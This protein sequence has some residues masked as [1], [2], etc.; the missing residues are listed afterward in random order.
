MTDHVADLDTLAINTI[1]TLAMDA[2][3]AAN[4]GHPGT[5]MSMAPVAY[6]LW[7]RLLRFDPQR[8]DWPN[9]DRFVLSVGH[10]S[11]LL[12]SLL[13]LS[14]VRASKPRAG[15]AVSLDD[16]KRFRQL[17]SPCAGHPEYDSDPAHW[18]A[19]VEA[20][21]G[22]LGQG[23]ANSVGMAIAS[24]WLAATYNR[25]EHALFDFD[26]YALCGDGCMMEGLSSEAASLA[27][28]LALDNLCW[29]YDSNRITIEGGTDLSFSEDIC[30]R[31]EACHWQVEQVDDA[32]DL[33]QVEAALRSFRQTRSKP[34]LVVVRSE[35]AYGSPN[36][37]GSASAHGSP[38][39]ADE[40]RLTKRGYGW[41][42]DER[43]LVPEGVQA[44]FS[45]HLGQRGAQARTE[46][47]R[48]FDDYK[49]R[50]PT[51][52][53]Q[54]QLMLARQLPAD[55]AAELTN[56]D[57][58]TKGLA[59]RSASGQALNQ[60]ARRVP[61]LLGGSADLAP[62]T[63]TRLTS[64]GSAHFCASNR[65]G[66][67]FHFGVRE[68]A[69]AAI[70]NGLALCHL[71]P[72]G[73]GFLIFSDYCRPAMRLSALMRL[74]V[75][76]VLTHDSI[77]I[78][79][80]GPTHQPVEQLASLRAIPGLLVIRPADA[81]EVVDAWRTIM[82]LAADPVVLVLSRQSLPTFD[83]QQMAEPQV[84]KGA[85]VLVDS[86]TRPAVILIAS[87]SEVALCVEAWRALC[88]DGIAARVVSM[89]SWELFE[90]QTPA[91]RDSVLPKAVGV[92]VAVEQGCS[93]G[94]DRYVGPRGRVI[95]IDSF[96]A[97]A[98]PEALR[99]A[100]GFTVEKI[101]AAARG[102]G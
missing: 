72:F 82:P 26:V 39:G 66:R 79:E 28:H 101:V 38:L 30:R 58:D 88:A 2:V 13:H 1:R 95:A 86:E 11:A 100:F 21:T 49:T 76:H 47:E 102:A 87:G 24:K 17:N 69:M 42:E 62:S 19:G 51:L 96:G 43:F 14:Q 65:A 41:P 89:P 97:S 8:P 84:A 44:H 46:W 61:W 48:R 80:D 31:F 92:R 74:P 98:P 34:T 56:F 55:W 10:A 75:V 5:P 94:W 85:Y 45:Q 40:V 71:R 59:G 35:I 18:V 83:R 50:Y 22:P 53:Q 4:S 23:L 3:E 16:L 7:Q 29:I 60:I 37:Q 52:A 33:A 25:P 12:Y 90:R 32:N 68:H 9:R 81:N 54:L 15:L 27:G 67:N 99:Q 64:E 78:G 93:L 91:Y 77:S 70:I 20:T 73:S 36:K 63:K 6:C 57:S